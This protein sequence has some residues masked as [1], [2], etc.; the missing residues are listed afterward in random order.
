MKFSYAWLQDHIAKPLPD[1]KEVADTLSI[2]SLEVE[3]IHGDVMEVKVLPHRQHDCL[4]HRGLAREIA[5]LF[6][7]PTKEKVIPNFVGSKVEVPK[8]TVEDTKRCPRYVG[9]RINKIKVAPSPDWLREKLESIGQRSISN[10]V[11]ITNFVMND[12]GQP[13]HAFDADKVVGG[14]TVR[15]AKEG[16][17]MTTLDGKDLLMKGIETVIA[18]DEG[19]LALAGV[20]GGMKALVDEKTKTIILESANFHPALTRKTSELHGIRTDASKRFEAEMTSEFAFE[21][22]SYAVRLVQEINEKC[23]VSDTT[24]IYP[25]K[26]IQYIVG[27]TLHDINGVLGSEYSEAEANNVLTR[28]GCS[29]EIIQNPREYIVEK[30]RTCVG[31]PYKRGASVRY[32]VPKETD[33]SSLPSWLYMHAGIAIPRMSVDQFMFGI[34]I[35]QEELLP[36]DLIFTNTKDLIHE[37]G[38]HYVTKEWLPGTPVLHGIDHVGMYLGDGKILHASFRRNSSMI[39]DLVTSP[40][41]QEEVY[42]RR[43]ILNNDPRFKVTIPHHRLDLRVKQDLIEEVGRVLGYDT[44]P[45]ILPK[46]EKKGLPHKRLFYETKIKNVLLANGYSE[47]YTYTFGNTGEVKIIKGLASDKEKLRASVGKGVMNALSMNI[48]NAPLLG[49]DTIRIFEF[50]NIFS[51]EHEIRHLSIAADDGK[52]KSSFMEEIEFVLSAIKR[53]LGVAKI[54]YDVVSG[55]PCCVEIDFDALIATLKEPDHYEPLIETTSLSTYTSVSPYP[56][57]ARDIAVWTSSTTTWEDIHSLALQVRDPHI[58]RIDCFDTF[59]KEVEQEG[60]KIAKTSY[61]FRVVLQ[62]KERTLTDEEANAIAEKMYSLLKE[63]GFEI[64]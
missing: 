15:V 4:S 63:K 24:D 14:I 17:T 51:K 32:D 9:V 40:Q 22:M 31:L 53:E 29:V 47:I 13:M 25:K 56:F 38:I 7:L 33:C 44:L 48:T 37:N 10:I 58:V 5:L 16:E 46:L 39:D 1:I 11:D 54:E 45:T 49:L 2:K 27:V 8:I 18:D 34:P 42:Y 61:A 6:D 60:E 50:G 41:F 59:T 36:G 28:S 57:I 26:E 35:T 21:A 43:L 52:K 30:A 3:E 20:K 64:R 55:K 19:I 12:L 62:S 23:S